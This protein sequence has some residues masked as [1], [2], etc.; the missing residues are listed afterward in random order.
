MVTASGDH[1]NVRHVDRGIALA[2]AMA[3]IALGIGVAACDQQAAAPTAV[4]VVAPTAT[5]SGQAPKT[6]RSHVTGA[7]GQAGQYLAESQ[8]YFAQEGLTVDFVKGDPSTGFVS[9]LAG[10]LDVSGNALD[11]GLFNAVQR[12]LDF[13][14]V[15]TQASSDPSGNGVFFVVR[16]DLI[17]K[18]QS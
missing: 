1:D 13:R 18:S 8:G 11:H 17:D 10:E 6:V 9:L 4:A 15:A 3:G 5:L 12:G 14:I 7:I 16:R 2:G